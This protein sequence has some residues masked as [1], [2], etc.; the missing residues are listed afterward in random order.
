M[1]W[2]LL[3]TFVA[4]SICVT[5]IIAGVVL[6][7]VHGRWYPELFTETLPIIVLSGLLSLLPAWILNR[8]MKHAFSDLKAGAL[9]LAEG[10]YQY[11]VL[12]GP[13][14]EARQLATTFNLMSDQIEVQFKTLE[15]D[16]KQLRTL[17]GGMIEGVIAIDQEQ[18][19]QFANGA[20]GR[21]LEFDPIGTVDRLIWEVV[22]IPAL[23]TAVAGVW[24][25][26]E[27]RRE[28][29]D[30]RGLNPRFLTAYIALLPPD[31]APGVVMVLH[32]TSEL[33]R[34][35]RLRQDFVANVSHE[36]KTP[37]AVIKACVEALQD[38]AKDEPDACN[39]FLMQLDDQA[40]RLEQLI[41]DLISL[42]RIQSG[43]ETFEFKR[44]DLVSVVHSC[45]QRHTQRALAKNMQFE[46]QL[47]TSPLSIWGDEDAVQ[48]IIDNLVDNAVKYTQAGGKIRLELSQQQGFAV[49]RVV[50]NGPGIPARDL[51]RIFE[52][53]Y[54]VDKA[55][56]RELGGT[57]L[58]LSIVKNLVQTMQGKVD[59]ES[60]LG[61]GTTFRVC[62]PISELVGTS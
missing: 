56:S 23:A 11:R 9:Q 20:A 8:M 28:N 37:L 24:Q 35:E 5:T 54:R 7:S 46:E 38:G 52:R 58:G 45:R 55:R 14:S 6:Q 40:N 18:R 25:S 33:R 42:A 1:Y 17:L 29:I 32:D 39:M 4:F 26:K 47:P 3:I 16:R 27:P 21:M 41:L 2:R 36:L 15:N 51:P 10:N 60:Q 19:I 49:I 50:D 31:D 34:L 12:G 13:W 57:G 62:F 61:V 30:I 53:F 44:L 22:R 43:E 59:V 48:E